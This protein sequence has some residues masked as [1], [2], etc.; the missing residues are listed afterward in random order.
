[1]KFKRSGTRGIFI[2]GIIMLSLVAASDNCASPLYGG[3]NGQS[4]IW[5]E[6]SIIEETNTL[7]SLKI[8]VGAD[9]DLN[10]WAR[11]G[12]SSLFLLPYNVYHIELSYEV[13]DVVSAS[14]TTLLPWPLQV[15]VDS[16]ELVWT[17]TNFLVSV[18][19]VDSNNTIWEETGVPGV[20]ARGS[21][22]NDNQWQWLKLLPVLVGVGEDFA[23]NQGGSLNQEDFKRFEEELR[24]L[25]Y[26]FA[27]EYGP[28]ISSLLIEK[29]NDDEIM[30]HVRNLSEILNDKRVLSPLTV[31]PINEKREGF[32][33]L[34]LLGRTSIELNALL[35]CMEEK[36]FT[37]E[38]RDEVS[39]LIGEIARDIKLQLKAIKKVA[40]VP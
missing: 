20:W 33:P 29:L 30:E 4:E 25:K 8:S 28:K 11:F 24:S 12:I 23:L 9:I 27:D 18:V 31:L 17:I 13:G 14:I 40:A 19:G 35:T 10:W 2:I 39:I 3:Y 16:N 37:E 6:V 15:G 7:F 38:T 21:D 36:V 34:G 5:S 22:N 1:M 32:D 26:H